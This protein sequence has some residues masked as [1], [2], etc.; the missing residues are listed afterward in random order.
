MNLH[1]LPLLVSLVLIAAAGA[2]LAL[3]DGGMPLVRDPRIPSTEA[4]KE[5]RLEVAE[6][7]AFA[8]YYG[9]EDDAWQDLNPFIPFGERQKERDQ[10]VQRRQRRNQRDDPVAVAQVPTLPEPPQRQAPVPKPKLKPLP[11]LSSSDIATP[12]VVGFISGP[13][14]RS[15]KARFGDG[16]VLELQPGDSHSGWTF[17]DVRGGTAFFLDAEGV[18]HG[19]FIA[20]PVGG[21]TSLGAVDH[22]TGGGAPGTSA[23]GSLPSMPSTGGADIAELIKQIQADPRGRAM[24]Q[25]NPDLQQMLQAN[26]ER[27]MNLFERLRQRAVREGRDGR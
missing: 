3:V 9:D 27:A 8:H 25:A 14:G 16:P 4:A 7:E 6:I 21:I 11:K 12:Q 18:E 24:L 17:V 10:L 26:P 1:Q 13:N 22:L 20:D 15:I 23:A 19:F 5:V 2:L